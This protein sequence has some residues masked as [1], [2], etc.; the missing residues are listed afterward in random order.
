MKCYSASNHLVE[1][2]LLSSPHGP[3][4]G[5]IQRHCCVVFGNVGY[6]E[7]VALES[8]IGVLTIQNPDPRF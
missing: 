7:D 8:L 6:S 4:C 2:K 1:K 5:D 3:N